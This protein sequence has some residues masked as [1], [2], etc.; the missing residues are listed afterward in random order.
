[1]KEDV[2]VVDLL[3]I[4]EEGGDLLA[5]GEVDAVKVECCP[6]RASSAPPGVGPSLPNNVELGIKLRVAVREGME[7]K[8]VGDND[9]GEK[10]GDRV[11]SDGAGELEM[12]GDPELVGETMGD[13]ED[14]VLAVSERE[15]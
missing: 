9:N 8:A 13:A 12:E 6:N 15:L 4:L 11:A 2:V 1:M 7:G 3:A 10:E 14:D 5:E